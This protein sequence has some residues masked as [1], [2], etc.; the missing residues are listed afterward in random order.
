MF[1]FIFLTALLFSS[2]KVFASNSQTLL[3]QSPLPMGINSEDPF[4]RR[5]DTIEEQREEFEEIVESGTPSLEVFVNSVST[6]LQQNGLSSIIGPPNSEELGAIPALNGL[7]VQ[8]YDKRPASAQTYLADLMQ[9]SKIISP[10]Q[11]QGIGFTS[12]D[13]ILQVWKTFRNIAYFFFVII[14]VAIGFMIMFRHKIGGQTV[15][16]VEQAI[17]S[18][19]VALIFVTFSYAIAGIL[20]DFMYLFMYLVISLFDG[21]TDMMNQNFLDL[22]W[23]LLTKGMA[24]GT[25]ADGAILKIVNAAGLPGVFKWMTSLTL[26]VI[27]AIAI[28]F[29]LFKL[30][31]ELLKSYVSIILSVAFAPVFL[32]IG[33]IPGQ[34]TFNKWIKNLIGNLAA[35]PAVL[36]LLLVQTVI[37]ESSFAGGK[38][39][40][41]PPFLIGQFGG[42]LPAMVAVG[43]LLAMP[44]TVKKIK[45]SLG[46]TEGVFGELA[47]VAAGRLKK[48]AAVGAAPVIG[49]Q[50]GV[51]GGVVGAAG[52]LGAG[53]LKGE[54]L[55]HSW[56]RAKTTAATG[57]KFG[58]LAPLGVQKAPGLIKSSASTIMKDVQQLAINDLT[59][60][61]LQKWAIEKN[62]RGRM[63]EAELV[64][65]ANTWK[66]REAGPT[67]NNPSQNTKLGE[68][69][70]NPSKGGA[71]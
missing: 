54:D 14:F 11:A 28:L 5:E 48:G 10:A 45:E 71:I 4:Y 36:L 25:T 61:R 37:N 49:A 22:G 39:G 67:T 63:A 52:G 15:A 38:G 42:A 17:P 31:F 65:R 56:Q 44:E 60:K 9:S 29:G 12:L 57:A 8:M 3:A 33:A 32:M 50:L 62:L 6:S 2:R 19:I 35:F 68:D 43:I 55:A 13:P 66:N 7:I 26:A 30:F 27:L 1:C 34:N 70:N 21:S 20:I 16:T 40:F 69:L 51:A 18:I 47:G 53:L 64:K 23:D 24:E 41:M 58:A 46:A 59:E